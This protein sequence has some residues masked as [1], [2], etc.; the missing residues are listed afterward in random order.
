MC[1]MSPVYIYPVVLLGWARLDC[2]DSEP[3]SLNTRDPVFN[4]CR[5]SLVGYKADGLP[6]SPKVEFLYLQMMRV[7]AFL[8][9]TL[10]GQKISSIL[11]RK[12]I[13]TR[14]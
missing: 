12:I 8:M 10:L 14:Y 9:R 2:D 5:S 7:I 4:D 13:D 11:L 1:H 6:S 3:V